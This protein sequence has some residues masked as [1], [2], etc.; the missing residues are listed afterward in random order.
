MLTRLGSGPENLPSA[1]VPSEVIET[2]E[3]FVMEPSEVAARLEDALL[4]KDAKEA[5]EK[6]GGCVCD[7]VNCVSVFLTLEDALMPRRRE[8][9][10][11][12]AS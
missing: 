11:V 5:R 12:G 2:L 1:P 6:Q 8:R 9:S 4:P 10:K 7:D 3:V